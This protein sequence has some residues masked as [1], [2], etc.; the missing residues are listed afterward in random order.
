MI[1]GPARLVWYL[2]YEN[3][4]IHF[5]LEVI[6]IGKDSETYLSGGLK[7]A[8]QLEMMVLLPPENDG[9]SGFLLMFHP[10]KAGFEK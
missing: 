6:L 5:A 7:M 10:I 4:N 2:R 3:G 8:L 9:F 1:L